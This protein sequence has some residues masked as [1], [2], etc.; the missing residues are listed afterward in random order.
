MA[1]LLLHS[2]A[3]ALSAPLLVDDPVEQ[4]ETREHAT[5]PVP[6]DV[7]DSSCECGERNSLKKMGFTYRSPSVG[8]VRFPW[9]SYSSMIVYVESDPFC[10]LPITGTV[11][12]FCIGYSFHNSLPIPCRAT[13]QSDVKNA[14]AKY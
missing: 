3:F 8:C 14:S 2:T 11:V 1:L 10:P 4:V 13:A 7:P 6:F 5:S 9:S 12:V